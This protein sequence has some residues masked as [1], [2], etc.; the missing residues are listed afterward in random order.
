MSARRRF[1]ILRILGTLVVIWWVALMV[2]NIRGVIRGNAG[3][4]FN[5][6]LIAVVLVVALVVG[7]LGY[8]GF[9]RKMEDTKANKGS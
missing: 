3:S 4:L 2:S 9:L 8:R 7:I 1:T 5:L 6:I